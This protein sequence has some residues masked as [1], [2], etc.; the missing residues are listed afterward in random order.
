MLTRAEK[1]QIVTSYIPLVDFFSQ[2][3]GPNCEVVLRDYHEGKSQIIHISHGEIS[4]RSEGQEISGLMLNRIMREDYHDT[5][6]I[7][8]YLLANESDQKLLR[9][10]TYYIKHEGELCGL[11]CINYDM[12]DLMRYRDFVNTKLLYGLCDKGLEEAPMMDHHLDMIAEQMIEHE[13]LYWDRQIPL[14]RVDLSENPIRRLYEKGVFGQKGT[15]S[16]V[17]ELLNISV[18]S[19]YRYINAIESNSCDN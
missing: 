9:A 7:S 3:S 12:T 16:R 11:L 17:S 14:S 8:N 10:S 6:Y 1:R 19:V 2:A 18:Q 4:G 13:F 15:V 5:D